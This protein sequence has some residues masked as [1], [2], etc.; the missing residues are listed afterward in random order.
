M[1]AVRWPDCEVRMRGIERTVRDMEA[2]CSETD[3]DKEAMT[4][5]TPVQYLKGVGPARA[6]VFAQ[7]RRADGGRS[8]G[9]LP[10]RLGLRAGADQ[11]RARC[12]RTSRRRSSAWWSPSTFRSHR[13]PPI[14]EAMVSDE[15]GVCRIIWFNGGYL[16]NQIRLGQVIVASGKPSVYKHQLQMTNPKFMMVEEQQHGGKSGQ[17]LQRRRLL[18]QR[19]PEQP[20]DQ[21]DHPAGAGSSR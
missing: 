17:A 7:A 4:L 8:A 18:R 16:R 21:A 5:S 12:G 10:A 11:D 13:R 3:Q 9:V 6:E 19:P 15:T 2:C 1:E 14:F 20:A